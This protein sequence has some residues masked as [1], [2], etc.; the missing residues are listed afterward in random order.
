MDSESVFHS[1]IHWYDAASTL[2]SRTHA[3]VVAVNE[4]VCVCVYLFIS[5]LSPRGYVEK[6]RKRE[7]HTHTKEQRIV[8]TRPM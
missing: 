7:E 4:K 6:G 8:H 1:L 2:C 3:E 5:M